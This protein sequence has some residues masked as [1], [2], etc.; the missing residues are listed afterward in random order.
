MDLGIQTAQIANRSAIYGI[1]PKARNRVNTAYMVMVFLGQ[2]TGTAVGNR[3]YA[4]G[5]WVVSGSAGVGFV[6]LGLGVC[7]LRGPWEKGWVGWR[8]GWGVRRRDLGVGGEEKRGVGEGRSEDGNGDA[9]G[10]VLEMGIGE[11]SSD[12]EVEAVSS[13]VGSVRELKVENLRDEEKE[14]KEVKSDMNPIS[15]SRIS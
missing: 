6:G 14:G 7:F 11:R 3:L 15:S 1:D 13:G 12:V 10:G 2:L 4:R 9:D 8:G 5:G